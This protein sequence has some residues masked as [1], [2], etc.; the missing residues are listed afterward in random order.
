[1][2]VYT[3]Q[4]HITNSKKKSAAAADTVCT[5]VNCNAQYL[6]CSVFQPY[7]QIFTISIS[8]QSL[9]CRT[10]ITPSMLFNKSLNFLS[11]CLAMKRHSTGQNIPAKL[12]SRVV[13]FEIC[14]T[15][16]DNSVS[17]KLFESRTTSQLLPVRE[18]CHNL[19]RNR[20]NTGILSW[21]AYGI[22]RTRKLFTLSLYCVAFH[23]SR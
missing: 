19:I 3:Y 16:L 2:R 7:K 18:N 4:L 12:Y 5:K 8:P 15:Y 10:I 20:D 6:P 22:T 9:F 14:V 17:S 13:M 21:A 23:T 1:M 11:E